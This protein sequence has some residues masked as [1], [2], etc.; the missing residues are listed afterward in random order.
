ML[1]Q[2]IDPPH[3][4][5]STGKLVFR[6]QDQQKTVAG[7]REAAFLHQAGDRLSQGARRQMER[8]R[9]LRGSKMG[10]PP[11]KLFIDELVERG[12]SQIICET[13]QKYDLFAYDLGAT[14]NECRSTISWP[15]QG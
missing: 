7:I 11:G 12:H 2:G 6:A 10:A 9:C 5:R 4:I 8:G 3:W 15:S 14:A 13:G 1:H